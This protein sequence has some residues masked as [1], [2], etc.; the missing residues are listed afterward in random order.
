MIL[1]FQPQPFYSAEL[2]TKVPASKFV[3]QI[4]WF[5]REYKRI[6]HIR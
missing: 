4:Y 5:L 3:Y 2:E 1:Y 6:K